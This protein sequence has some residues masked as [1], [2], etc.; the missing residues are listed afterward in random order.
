MTSR[1]G[2]MIRRSERHVALLVEDAAR[3]SV[4]VGSLEDRVLELVE[5]L[6]E[7]VDLGPVVID[8]RVDDAVEQRDRPFAENLGVPRAR[9]RAAR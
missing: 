3:T 7:L 8:H 6:L 2:V 9:A 1:C 4:G 5:P